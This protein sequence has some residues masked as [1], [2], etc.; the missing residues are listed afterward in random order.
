M[1]VRAR[2]STRQAFAFPFPNKIAA[3]MQNGQAQGSPERISVWSMPTT[4]ASPVDGK[5]NVLVLELSYS[6]HKRRAHNEKECRGGLMRCSVHAMDESVVNCVG[7]C[8]RSFDQ[9]SPEPRTLLCF[10]QFSLTFL[11]YCSVTMPIS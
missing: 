1:K 5:S 2:R 9:L 3:S 11:G 6:G 8:R 4:F 10:E 7:D